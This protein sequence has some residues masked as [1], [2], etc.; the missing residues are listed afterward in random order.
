MDTHILRDG[1]RWKPKSPPP[2]PPFLPGLAL[3]WLHS[4]L[5]LGRGGI[6][7][8]AQGWLC[9]LPPRGLATPV[10]LDPLPNTMPISHTLG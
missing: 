7:P 4:W 9:L 1:V 6:L 8:F 2:G 5:I 10:P 3:L